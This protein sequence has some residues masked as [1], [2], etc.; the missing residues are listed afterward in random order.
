MSVAPH[1]PSAAQKAL[2]IPEM[3]NMILDATKWSDNSSNILDY[4]DLK[5][6]IC[7]NRLWFDVGAEKLWAVLESID[8]LLEVPPKR[9]QIYASKMTQILIHGHDLERYYY[10]YWGLIFWRLKEIILDV[11]AWYQ[12][13]HVTPY[14]VPSLQSFS[15]Y[16]VPESNFELFLCL[17]RACPYLE[18]I[19]ITTPKFMASFESFSR[20]IR[21]AQF[22]KTV[23]ISSFGREH[24]M[25]SGELLSCLAHCGRLEQLKLPWCWTEAAVQQAAAEILHSGVVPFS[26]IKRLSLLSSSIAVNKLVPLVA[27]TTQLT[28]ILRDSKFDALAHVSSLQNLEA[29][30]VFYQQ[31]EVIPVE[32]LMALGA[33]SKLT[34]LHLSPLPYKNLGIYLLQSDFSDNDCEA[35]ACRWPYLRRLRLRMQCNIST[36]AVELFLAHC[37]N[38]HTCEIFQP[39]DTTNLFTTVPGY[40]V[41]PQLTK[42]TLSYL[43]GKGI[44]RRLTPAQFCY[45]FE[46]QFPGVK[47]MNLW[48]GNGEEHDYYENA[49]AMW[50][51]RRAGRTWDNES[52]SDN[53]QDSDSSGLLI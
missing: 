23:T 4:N 15:F 35:L 13:Q 44:M 21:H 46:T 38:L 43:T 31:P 3:V 47:K 39:L 51:I 2:S 41:F 25:A 28:L 22:L 8:R 14:L 26:T 50:R 49:F 27:N 24:F 52:D 32:S 5:R 30:T 33:L 48:T 16:Y 10:E 12:T 6:A 37:P 7:V 40:M 18:E 29:L 53:S 9:R 11:H 1:G 34:A 17:E 36:N 42:L 20:F 45:S 19:S